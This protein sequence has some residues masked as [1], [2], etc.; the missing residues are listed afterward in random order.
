MSYIT[1]NAD[2]LAMV[3]VLRISPNISITGR[4]TDEIAKRIWTVIA[5]ANEG[6]DNQGLSLCIAEGNTIE[7]AVD[8]WF[9]QTGLDRPPPFTIYQ[10]KAA[11][12]TQ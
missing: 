11:A 1:T 12:I 2:R 8:V 10:A 7:E 5:M 6:S 3:D 9:T 4:N